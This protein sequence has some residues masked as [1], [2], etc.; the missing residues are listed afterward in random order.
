MIEGCLRLLATVLAR[1]IELGVSRSVVTMLDKDGDMLLVR[2]AWASEAGEQGTLPREPGLVALMR[3]R[4]VAA[5]GDKGD[6]GGEEGAGDMVSVK[7]RA[8]VRVVSNGEHGMKQCLYL[9]SHKN[10]NTADDALSD[11]TT[12][13]P[14]S[15]PL[16]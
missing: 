3:M 4:A 15:R 13:R 7:E 8:V 16:Q 11:V 14:P 5:L 1:G 10:T 9:Q 12:L 6:V 2:P